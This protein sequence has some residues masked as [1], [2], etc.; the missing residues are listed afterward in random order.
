MFG[1][2]LFSIGGS[3]LA[4]VEKI[5]ERI[6]QGD[7]TS[8]I[9]QTGGKEVLRSVANMQENL[10]RIVSGVINNT[11][12]LAVSSEE[13][14]KLSSG[15]RGSADVMARHT[16][17]VDA[18]TKEMEENLQTISIV[19]SRLSKNM[20]AV[21]SKA[22]ES[23]E[24]LS[25]VATATEEMSATITE[26]AQNSEQARGIAEKAAQSV[27]RASEKVNS[28]GSAA[29]EINNVISVITEI[30][31]QTK[32]L[33]LNATIEA[34]RAGEAGK[35]FAV[36]A[37]EVKDLAT[38]T[39]KATDDIRH[40]VN[41]IQTATESTI[42]E[43]ST[44]HEVINE[45]NNVVATIAAA[46]EEQSVTTKDIAES[47][48]RVTDGIKEMTSSVHNASEAVAEAN[49]LISD[50]AQLAHL[51]SESMTE[52]ATESG[53]IKA[54]STKVYASGMEVASLGKDIDRKLM[55]FKLAG[56]F[57]SGRTGDE[58]KFIS[59]TDEFSVGIAGIDEQHKKIMDFINQVHGAVKKDKPINEIKRILEDMA[60]FT[61]D[62]FAAEEKYFAQ[63][64]YPETKK[65][66]AI[67]EKL[68]GKVSGIVAQIN[69]GTEVNLIDVLI[70]LKDWLQTHILVEDKQYGPF[71][72]KH[73]IR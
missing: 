1:K 34:A 3:S 46:V 15:M 54:D 47:I 44:I 61:V 4:E 37:N 8:T 59:F 28:L 26:I 48:S 73:G 30:S 49:R 53:K 57:T 42:K 70:F 35:G 50:S 39:S 62:H 14:E 23:S 67:H 69:E 52:V 16:V 51:V 38:Q 2:G 17:E 10:A 65:H 13:L 63:F 36:V 18:S 64:N 43:I 40:K 6:A 7:L 27:M 9:S 33:A 20:D 25:I 29:S 24:N 58:R 41:A 32:L 60:K 11:K 22:S 66:K 72:N 55:N 71:L 19:A 12:D 21:S 31:D 68:L 56:K 45:V 5:I